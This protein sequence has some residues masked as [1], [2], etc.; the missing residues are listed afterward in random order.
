MSILV[1]N[2][3]RLGNPRTVSVLRN[4]TK[5]KWPNLVFLMETKSRKSRL[6]EFRRS[7]KLE[8]C[9]AVDCVGMSGGIALLWR[10]TWQVKIINYTRWHI[11]ALIQEGD[12]GP[13]WQFTGFY[14]HP[15]SAKRNSNWQLLQML[16]PP[17]PMAWLCAGDFNEILH[18]K[19]KVGEASRPYRQ[20]ETFRRA[21]DYC[22]LN[23][24]HSQGLRFTWSSNR[25]GKAFI[26]EM[27][28]RAFA[29]KEWSDL[30]KS[31]SSTT[32]PAIQSDHS[33]LVIE[34]HTKGLKGKKRGNCF[35]YEVAWEMREDY[36][37][38]IA[39]A[40]RKDGGG[41]TKV[42]QLRQKLG[43]CQ[44]DLQNW[45]NKRQ[46]ERHQQ[47]TKEWQDLV[48]S[49][50][51]ARPSNFDECL[52]AMDTKLAGD[53]KT[54]L[55]IPFNREEIRAAVVQ[56]NPLGSPGPGGFP[57]HFYQKHWEVVSE[58][59]YKLALQTLN[60]GGSISEL[61][62]TLI[63]LIPKVKSPK[64]V[65]DFRPISLSLTC[66]L[67]RAEL[68][69]NLTPVPIGRGPVTVNHI[70][71]TDDSLLFFKAAPEELSCV[72][73]K[74]KSSI[75]FSKNTSQSTQIQLLQVAG[76]KSSGTFERYLG[77]PAL[78]GRSKVATF[79]SLIDRTWA[80]IANWK[81]KHLSAAGKEVLLKAVL[82]AIPTYTIGM[83]LLPL[84]ISNKLNQ[85]LRKFWWGFD[86]ETSKIQ[87]VNWDKISTEKGSGGLGFRDLRLFNLALLS[88]QGWRIIQNPSS[89]MAKVLKQK[90]FSRVDFTEAQMGSR[91]S[92]VWRS[93]KA[94]ANLLKKG[95]MW[96][97]GNGSKVNIWSDRWLPHS[98]NHMVLSTR[99][100][101]CWCEKVSDPIDPQ[102]LE[103]EDSLLHELFNQHE[104]ENIK[105]I[106]LSK[107]GREDRLVWEFTNN[108][109]YTV[110]SGYHFIKEL[111]REMEG[112]TSD[113]NKNKLFWKAI[114][115]LDTTPQTKMFLWR[116]KPQ[117]MLHGGVVQPQ[118]CGIKGEKRC[119]RCLI[120]VTSSSICG[121]LWQLP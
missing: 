27:I 81:T 101:D 75:F 43:I 106:P 67:N 24:I 85:M 28:D 88:K 3:R 69:G 48:T 83:F 46:Q 51:L 45:N 96:R 73:N 10:E 72:L 23:D 105:T 40:W 121:S 33:P 99:D 102:R 82:Q 100:E 98:H 77:L 86:E 47:S 49:K 62:D 19:E 79:H 25:G 13:T 39:K 80:R 107:G 42:K 37:K 113:R 5:D 68:C 118:M 2:C 78:V 59:V 55:M 22:G 15:E 61:N 120:T 109:L 94:G 58:D 12:L 76:I 108:G 8:G 87:W 38:T 66:L 60:H 54:W 84:S 71:F 21:I 103:W 91:P 29:N 53:M 11:S 95:L 63:T 93:I 18:Q 112:E 9:F 30:F 7:L 74:E 32:L 104:V 89:L 35:R 26:K 64:R 92:F 57:A 65:T 52:S 41:E 6:E 119:K 20:I 14:G 16:K 17:N 70:F 111:D 34:K 4:L 31:G 97:I 116:Q 114:W 115:K 90:Y 44:R 117:D 56:M 110:K 50:K 36:L 1:W